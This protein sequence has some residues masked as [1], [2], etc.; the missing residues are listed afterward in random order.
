MISILKL[1]TGVKKTFGFIKSIVS[2]QC[3]KI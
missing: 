3:L 1:S 2:Q